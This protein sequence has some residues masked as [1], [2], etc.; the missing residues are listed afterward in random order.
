MKQK[1]NTYFTVAKQIGKT[2]EGILRRSVQGSK[3]DYFQLMVPHFQNGKIWFAEELRE[4]AAMQELLTELYYVT[5]S[6]IGAVHDDGIDVISQLSQLRI[7]VPSDN[8]E[9]VRELTYN[10]NNDMWEDFEEPDEP[11]GSSVIF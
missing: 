6:G 11:G 1:H 4:T 10:P 7:L 3:F 2:T 9:A 5:H 8:E